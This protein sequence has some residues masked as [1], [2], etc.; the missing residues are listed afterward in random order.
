MQPHRGGCGSIGTLDEINDLSDIDQPVPD[1]DIEQAEV[2]LGFSSPEDFR[3]FV[4]EP[5]VEAIQRLPSLRWFVRH[6]GV[7]LISLE[8]GSGHTTRPKSN[9]SR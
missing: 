7:G 1:E 6:P 8:P 3:R 4:S 5:D 2:I 9:L